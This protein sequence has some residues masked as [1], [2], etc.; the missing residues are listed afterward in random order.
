[1]NIYINPKAYAN[2][3]KLANNNEISAPALASLILNTL[4]DTDAPN[5]MF[6]TEEKHQFTKTEVCTELSPTT[7]SFASLVQNMKAS[8]S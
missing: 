3:V 6:Y 2:L 5:L 7:Q 8:K 4:L 1:M